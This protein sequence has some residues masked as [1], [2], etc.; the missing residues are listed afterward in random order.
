MHFSTG[1]A[2]TAS[3]GQLFVFVLGTSV[4]DEVAIVF[5]ICTQIL[6]YYPHC[7]S[8]SHPSQR[9]T[10][11]IMLKIIDCYYHFYHRQVI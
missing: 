11:N 3:G 7:L 10:G 4:D 8:S 9:R 6:N 1:S 5:G 2:F